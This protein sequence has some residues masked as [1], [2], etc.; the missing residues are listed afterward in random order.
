MYS[1]VH[2]IQDDMIKLRN[3]NKE[4]ARQLMEEYGFTEDQV[5]NNILRDRLI[6][7]GHYMHYFKPND[8]RIY[9]LIH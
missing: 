7:R 1:F 8:V 4:I 9:N 5:F 2:W 6:L 3:L